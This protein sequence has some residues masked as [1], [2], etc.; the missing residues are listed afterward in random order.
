MVR[1]SADGKGMRR[2]NLEKLVLH[3]PSGV[4]GSTTVLKGFHV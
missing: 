1:A 4:S 3:T 2:G